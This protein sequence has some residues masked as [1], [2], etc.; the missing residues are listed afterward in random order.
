M[1]KIIGDTKTF[2]IGININKFSPS[3]VGNS[4]LWINS[5]QVGDFEDENILGPFLNSLMRVARNHNKLTDDRLIGKSNE[6]I[7]ST[8]EPF[9]ERKDNFDRLSKAKRE[10]I[11]SFDKFF[12]HWGENFDNYVL[13]PYVSNG[14][15]KFMWGPIQQKGGQ[16]NRI[17]YFDVKIEYI[18]KCYYELVES[19]PSE[20]WPKLISK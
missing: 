9:Y 17:T 5:F 18:Q 10:V 3:L 19:I 4:C 2:A 15:C 8:I 6:E 14:V 1:E 16:K 12:F 20:F 11:V 13:I 7:F